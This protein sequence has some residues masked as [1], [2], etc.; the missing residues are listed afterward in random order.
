MCDIPRKNHAI[1][2]PAGTVFSVRNMWQFRPDRR[3]VPEYCLSTSISATAA[4]VADARKDSV[5]I[6]T[7]IAYTNTTTIMAAAKELNSYADY[8]LFICLII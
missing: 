5:D 2:M 7:D 8:Y 1:K 6:C 3:C 4:A